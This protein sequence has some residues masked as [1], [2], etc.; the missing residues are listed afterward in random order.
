MN[1]LSIVG[2]IGKVGELRF[3]QSGKAVIGFSVAVDNGKDSDGNKRAA[4]WFEIT[5]WEKQAESLEKYLAVG[6]RIGITGQA[7]MQIDEKG[8]QKYHKLVIDFPRVE[9]MGDGNK[10]KDDRPAQTR[11]AQNNNRGSSSRPAQ[12]NTRRNEPEIDGSDIPF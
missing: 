2:R 11:P 8:D 7:R 4:T 1:N 5:L 9:L 12:N 6:D 3:T 10:E